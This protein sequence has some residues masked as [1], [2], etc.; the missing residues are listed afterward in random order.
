[1]VASAFLSVNEIERE[2]I[3][4]LKDLFSRELRHAKLELA[5]VRKRIDDKLTRLKDSQPSAPREV[6]PGEKVPVSQ[7]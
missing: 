5:G 6:V 7:S 1:M 2:K 3:E 4:A